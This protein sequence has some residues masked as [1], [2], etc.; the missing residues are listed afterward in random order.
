MKVLGWLLSADFD[1]DYLKIWIKKK[2]DGQTVF[3]Y[4]KYIPSFYAQPKR[5]F[6]MDRAQ[7]LLSQHPHVKEIELCK[8]YVS[9]SDKEKTDVLRVWP[10]SPRNFKKIVRDVDEMEHFK[11]FN[12]D[13]PITQTYFYENDLFPTALCEFDINE[14]WKPKRPIR[15]T[16]LNPFLGL[17]RKITLHDK[18]TNVMY[19]F[20]RPLRMV[21]IDLGK[22]GLKDNEGSEF[23]KRNNRP[24]L[25]EPIISIQI[26]LVD[27][28]D[29]EAVSEKYSPDELSWAKDSEERSILVI[30]LQ[31]KT[32]AATI[33]ALSKEIMD[34]DPDV[35]LCSGGDEYFFPYLV[36]RASACNSSNDLILSRDLSS[37]KRNMF[38][39]GGDTHYFSYGQIMHRS[40][41]QFYLRGRICIDKNI[42]GSLHFSLY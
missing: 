23:R 13:V 8:R 4:Q 30:H 16:R 33:R 36:A 7:D 32:E 38:T 1:K 31:K 37:L 14:R 24:M 3:A 18:N 17:I 40:K 28:F 39:V 35:I 19:E 34:L 9:V 27:G 26:A 21:N 20:P 42:Y 41:H 12:I 11:L 25:N 22:F 10:D 2:E 6:S 15:T 5:H 29:I